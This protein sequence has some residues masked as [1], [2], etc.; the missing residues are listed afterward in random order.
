MKTKLLS[1]FSIVS[2]VSLFSCEYQ[3]EFRKHT[4]LIMR[5]ESDYAI[6]SLKFK[7]FLRKIKGFSPD[8]F[9]V[10]RKILPKDSVSFPINLENNS[11][12]I[13][14]S[15]CVLEIYSKK[16]PRSV[17]KNDKFGFEVQDVSFNPVYIIRNDTI[18]LCGYSKNKGFFG[19]Y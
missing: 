19:C 10:S 12:F 15:Y 3:E 11:S 18:L 9:I 7:V 8:S 6:D 13:Y 4:F 5:N 16:N 14:E 1:I 17:L 2:L